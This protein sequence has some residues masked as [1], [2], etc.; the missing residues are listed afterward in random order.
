MLG[1]Y[2]N[3]RLRFRSGLEFSEASASRMLASIPICSSL[4]IAS[5]RVGF[6][7]RWEAIQVWICASSASGIRTGAVDVNLRP[8]G[9]PGFFFVTIFS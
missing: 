6:R 8:A 3:L 5:D 1:S 2:L 4:R 9:R 7:S